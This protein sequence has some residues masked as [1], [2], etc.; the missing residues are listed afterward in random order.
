MAVP[1]YILRLLVLLLLL[2]LISISSAS[3]A[4]NCTKSY[5]IAGEK[6]LFSHCV[7]LGTQ[8]A[9]L[10][11]SLRPAPNGSLDVIFSGVAPSPGGWVGWGINP[12]RLGMVGTQ[13]FIGFQASNGSTLLT[14]DV[15]KGTE[16]G[17]A[18]VCTPI[19]LHVLNMTINIANGNQIAMFVSISWPIPNVDPSSPVINHV[20]NRGPSVYNFQPSSHGFSGADLSSK[21]AINMSSGILFYGPPNN[22]LENAHAILNTVGWGIL[23]PSGVIAARYM[24]PFVDPAWFYTHITIQILGYILGV[25]GWATGLSLDNVGAR[26]GNPSKHR[27]IGFTLFGICTLQ[28]MAI[29]LRPNKDHKLRKG[30]NLYHYSLAASILILGIVN[31]FEGFE[32]MSP[33]QKWRDT[34]IAVLGALGG[35]AIILEIVTWI[36]VCRKRRYS[37]GKIQGA[38]VGGA[39]QF[40]K[41]PVG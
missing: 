28:M 33:P 38:T 23:L 21:I 6:R 19:S 13:T 12:Y 36:Y 37:Q 3:T 41:G 31:I 20:W 27:N 10:A 4:V 29:F 22:L 26:G 18:F 25:A 14:F 8:E 17:K 24:K 39:Y 30:W 34:Y 2:P 5:N 1:V 40:E 16:D 9:S 35:V 32:I 7:V 11:W 15:T